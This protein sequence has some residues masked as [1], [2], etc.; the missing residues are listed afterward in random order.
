MKLRIRAAPGSLL[1]LALC[2]APASGGRSGRD[3]PLPTD[4]ACS[5]GVLNESVPLGLLEPLRRWHD[6]AATAD[7]RS[8]CGSGAGDAAAATRRLF[9]WARLNGMARTPAPGL[10]GSRLHA[11]SEAP[12]RVMAVAVG[13]A[14]TFNTPEVRPAV[15]RRFL[16]EGREVD[17]FLRAARQSRLLEYI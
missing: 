1:V 9:A 3:P 5:L 11:P 12:R 8:D 13:Y 16:C 6:R 14:R 17:S 4:T 10:P 7:G 15:T 2:A